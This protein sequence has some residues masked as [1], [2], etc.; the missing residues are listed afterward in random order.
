MNQI[1]A[2]ISLV[3]TSDAVASVD[4]QIGDQ[5]FTAVL[6]DAPEQSEWLQVGEEVTMLF[7]ETEVAIGIAPIGLISLRNQLPCT[8]T[9][10]IEGKVLSTL[11]LDFQG[12]ELQSVIT[13]RSLN[14]LGL[15]VNKEVIALV[16]AN[17]ISLQRK[18]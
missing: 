7:K 14:R 11:T 18:H 2:T 16:K 15:H 8:I 10:I 1:N 3:A 13:R 6:I 5:A 17:E 12:I 4:L 9:D